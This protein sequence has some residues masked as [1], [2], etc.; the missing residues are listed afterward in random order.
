MRLTELFEND[1]NEDLRSEVI[2][3]LTAVSAEGISE[4]STQNLLNDL[5]QQG[6]A[7]DAES[8]LLLLGDMEVVS[9]ATDEK[10]TI[11]TTDADH[12]VG[13]QTDDVKADR[14]DNMAAT[15]ATKDLGEDMGTSFAHNDEVI[16]KRGNTGVVYGKEVNGKVRVSYHSTGEKKVVRTANLEINDY[17]NSDEEEGRA[18]DSGEVDPNYGIE[19][20]ESLARMQKLAGTKR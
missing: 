2:T 6:F 16:D 1:Y 8:L 13:A 18:M 19:F 4:I 3:L 14:V 11:S 5:E 10:I 9:L 17:A 7:V 12:M 15:Q 20:E